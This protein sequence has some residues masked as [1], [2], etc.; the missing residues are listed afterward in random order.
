MPQRSKSREYLKW[1]AKRVSRLL[2]AIRSNPGIFN[3]VCSEM[4]LNPKSVQNNMYRLRISCDRLVKLEKRI[5]PIDMKQDKQ[6]DLFDDDVHGFKSVEPTREPSL[7][8]QLK[9]W[10]RDV[11]V[12]WVHNGPEFSKI[13]IRCNSELDCDIA[14]DKARQWQQMMKRCG[15][16]FKCIVERKTL[17][18]WK[19]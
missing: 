19:L 6:F 10:N 17:T 8:M 15:I 12:E 11:V 3:A 2:A 9:G 16:D 7:Y 18:L 14:Y 1:I 4:G 5:L 13:E